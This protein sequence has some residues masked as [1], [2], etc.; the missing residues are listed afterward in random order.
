MR[1]RT[2]LLPDNAAGCLMLQY[3]ICI[4]ESWLVAIQRWGRGREAGTCVG[5]VNVSMTYM[6]L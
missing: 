2:P 5:G 3:E 6:R 4:Y 1:Y